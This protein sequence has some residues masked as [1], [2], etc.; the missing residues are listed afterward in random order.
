[1]EYEV[2]FGIRIFGV[3]IF[4]VEGSITIFDATHEVKPAVGCAITSSI[5][6]TQNVESHPSNFWEV[7]VLAGLEGASDIGVIDVIVHIQD[8]FHDFSVEAR[9]LDVVVHLD[10][11][12]LMRRACEVAVVLLEVVV[13][14]GTG[15]LQQLLWH[16]EVVDQVPYL[17]SA[18]A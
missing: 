10:V 16:A 9:T 14:G 15:P 4:D 11:I 5:I 7:D 17:V 3:D 6:G 12:S 1:M 18:A 2:F 8:H 13:A